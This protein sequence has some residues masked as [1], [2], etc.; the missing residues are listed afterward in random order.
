MLSRTSI[1]MR[2]WMSLKRMQR[3]MLV[4]SCTHVSSLVF[5]TRRLKNRK[6]DCTSDLGG[7]DW[8]ISL[9]QQIFFNLTVQPCLVTQSQ[10][11][12]SGNSGKSVCIAVRCAT[13]MSSTQP[14][15][16][17]DGSHPAVAVKLSEAESQRV[18]QADAKL[19]DY[20]KQDQSKVGCW[21][22]LSN[23]VEQKP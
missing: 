7:Q 9:L 11:I 1:W 12:H 15:T 21:A 23:V 8:L 4:D 10:H 2:H 5:P 17:S 3:I 22:L 6:C 20:L 16:G 19:K 14:V 13:I 18:Q